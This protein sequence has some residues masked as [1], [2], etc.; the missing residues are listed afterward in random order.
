[1]EPPPAPRSLAA[2]HRARAP[3]DRRPR[4]TAADRDPR[5]RLECRYRLAPTSTTP[6]AAHARFR[7]GIH[8]H[9]TD[10]HVGTSLSILTSSASSVPRLRQL[11]HLVLTESPRTG[12]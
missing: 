6:T 4:S 5:A 8:I 7:F 10:L 11:T 2:P 12:G 9:G 3:A 1:M